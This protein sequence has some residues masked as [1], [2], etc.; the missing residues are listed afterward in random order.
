MNINSKR[1]PLMAFKTA[2]ATGIITLLFAQAHAAALDRSGQPINAFLQDGN[3]AEASISVL[4]ADVSGS[5]RSTYIV[6]NTDPATGNMANNYQFYNAALKLQLTP[7]LSFGLIY[8]QPFGADVTYDVLPNSTYSSATGKT[9]TDVSTQNLSFLFGY[10]PTSNWNFYAAPVYQTIKGNL[11]INGLGFGEANGYSYNVKQDSAVGWLAGAAYQIPEIALKA[12]LTYRSE[13]KHEFSAVE[14]FDQPLINLVPLAG[15]GQTELTTPQ[16]VN[17]DFQTGLNP[18]TLAFLNARWVNWK[19]FYIRPYQFGKVTELLT[20]MMLNNPIAL[21]LVDY[22]KDQ[23]SVNG[24]LAKKLTTQWSVMALAGW[25]SGTG[26]PTS[27]LGPIDGYWTAGLGAQFNPAPHYF[28]QGAFKYFWFGDATGHAATYAIPG[29]EE[30]AKVADYSD[31]SAWG[32]M[33]KM[34]YTF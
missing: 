21:N 16:S 28:I 10:Q 9:S 8:D 14:S 18:S 1:K 32:Y 15:T 19:D 33:L 26:N 27:T 29:N 7:Q 2:L 13:I 22:D 6:P 20:G 3:Y 5:A 23:I 11:D 30:A 4:D 12:A 25:D 24:G 17:F 34:G 31:N